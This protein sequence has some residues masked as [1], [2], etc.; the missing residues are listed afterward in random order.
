MP[1]APG[2]GDDAG[3]EEEGV[4]GFG[5]YVVADDES[6]EG[7]GFVGHALIESAAEPDLE[8]GLQPLETPAD[9][10]RGTGP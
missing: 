3:G 2:Q 5:N 8:G 9:I 10:L 4:G 6:I 1:N 7:E